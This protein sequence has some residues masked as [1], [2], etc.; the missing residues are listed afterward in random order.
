MEKIQIKFKG[1]SEVIGC[2]GLALIVLTD[3][4]EKRQLGVVCESRIKHEFLIRMGE[5]PLKSMFLPEVLSSLI[6]TG[7]YELYIYAIYEG[8]YESE[9]I[10]KADLSSTPILVSDGILLATIA[11]LDIFINE[12]L[13]MQQSVPYVKDS[14]QMTLPLNALNE[15]MLELSLDKAIEGENYELA[16][17]LRD[18]IKRRKMNK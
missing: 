1:L 17:L 13:F 3:D 5:H 9:L 10:N 4:P 15:N 7:E 16:S 11:K 14:K 8:Q 6:N 12:S 2:H 18:E